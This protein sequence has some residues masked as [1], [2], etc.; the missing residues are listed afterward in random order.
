[1]IFGRGCWRSYQRHVM[2]SEGACPSRNISAM[3]AI[4]RLCRF[5]DR[6]FFRLRGRSASERPGFEN[7]IGMFRLGH[8][9]SLNMTN[10]F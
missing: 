9:P 3:I 10:Y 4:E 1:M 5:S 8:A 2:L 6:W 7:F